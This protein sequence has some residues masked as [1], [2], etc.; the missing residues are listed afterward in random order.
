M[1]CCTT[2]TVLKVRVSM[3]EDRCVRQ[4]V[5]IS[6]STWMPDFETTAKTGWWDVDNLLACDPVGLPLLLL[7]CVVRDHHPASI[8]ATA[9]PPTGYVKVCCKH[10]SRGAST[11]A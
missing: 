8:S 4:T 1:T 7:V 3:R 2:P 9:L 10:P 11:L 6:Y 5:G